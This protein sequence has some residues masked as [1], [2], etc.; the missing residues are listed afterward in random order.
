[1]ASIPTKFFV[2]GIFVTIISI[3]GIL[4]NGL[5]IIILNLKSSLSSLKL[6]PTLANLLTSQ[7]VF[8]AIF[9]LVT[10]LV[11]G[12]TFLD[13]SIFLFQQK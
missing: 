12:I 8:D 1:M 9:L 3:I 10:F 2:E 4:A 5:T 13:E 7:A 11:R 6:R